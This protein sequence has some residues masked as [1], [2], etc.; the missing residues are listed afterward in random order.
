M[1]TEYYT[2]VLHSL[3]KTL[4]MMMG[5]IILLWDG[6]IEYVNDRYCSYKVCRYLVN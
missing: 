5:N 1:T 6:D 4:T 2:N 3:I